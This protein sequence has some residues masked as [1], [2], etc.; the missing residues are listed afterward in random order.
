MRVV[1]QE[2]CPA[3]EVHNGG[4]QIYTVPNISA[5]GA[6]GMLVFSGSY[7]GRR[8]KTNV[9]VREKELKISSHIG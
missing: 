6:T 1:E 5:V 3:A 7:D 4:V 8:K 2:V 9:L